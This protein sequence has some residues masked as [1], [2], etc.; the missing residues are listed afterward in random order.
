[1]KFELLFTP[2]AESH[3]KTLETN[4]A[5]KTECKAVKKALAYMET[6]IRHKSLQTH[7][8]ESLKGPNSEDIFEA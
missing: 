1:M 5:Q 4:P 3:L 7:K 8:Y 2:T 6:N